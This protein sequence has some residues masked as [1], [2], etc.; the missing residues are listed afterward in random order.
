[1]EKFMQEV[2]NVYGLSGVIIVTLGFF[3]IKFPNEVK[4]MLKVFSV[5]KHRDA[6]KFSSKPILKSK[7]KYWMSFK[8]D[9]LEM[10]ED[11]RTKIFRDLLR[12]MFQSYYD[13]FMC[14]ED[15]DDFNDLD[16]REVY[17]RIVQ[18]FNDVYADFEDQARLK[19]IPEVVLVKYQAWHSST[20]DYTLK[21]AELV[22]QSPVNDTNLDIMYSVYLLVITLLEITI[23]EAEKVLTGL[24][25][26]L[27]GIVYDG[28]TIG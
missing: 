2:F 3:I 25:G 7:L 20:L 23:A 17:T 19:G 9:S 22:S 8:I 24:N 15:Q 11:G 5:F 10:A 13:N 6:I 12:I 14:I 18:A 21:H 27:T 28:Y 1:M 4:N 16:R 26:E